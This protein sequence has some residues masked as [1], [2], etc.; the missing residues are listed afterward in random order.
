MKHLLILLAILVAP[1]FVQAQSGKAPA[2]KWS[3]TEHDFGKIKQNNPQT[4]E[5]KFTNTGKAPLMLTD[6]KGSCGCTATDYTKEAI[7][8]GKQGFVKATYNAAALGAFTK[9]VTVTSNV[10]GGPMILTIKGEVVANQ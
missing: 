3:E 7:A 2:F 8:P 9:T 1:L 6:V 5:F 10:E 4:V